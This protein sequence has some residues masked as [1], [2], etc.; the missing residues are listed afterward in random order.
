MLVE[1]E[2]HERAESPDRFLRTRL[3]D[4]ASGEAA[5]DR[6]RQRDQFV[7]RRQRREQGGQRHHRADQRAGVRTGDESGEKRAFEREVSD[8]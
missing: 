5:A 3:A 8:R 6:E 2:E 7:M 4:A 1:I